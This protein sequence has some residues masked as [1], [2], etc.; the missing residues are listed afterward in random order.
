MLSE[1]EIRHLNASLAHEGNA[2]RTPL[3]PDFRVFARQ[4]A[5]EFI[6]FTEV[7]DFGGQQPRRVAV[8]ELYFGTPNMLDAGDAV[9]PDSVNHPT[10]VRPRKAPP[11]V[12]HQPP[13]EKYLTDLTYALRN[14]HMAAP[15]AANG[16]KPTANFAG[17]SLEP[18][19]NSLIKS[20]APSGTIKSPSST[21]AANC[22]PRVLTSKRFA[23]SAPGLIST[24]SSVG[25]VA[26]RETCPCTSA[27]VTYP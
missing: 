12:A 20:S 18:F 15:Y 14:S 21:T 22:R 13:S 6:D 2:V 25:L 8:L 11:V 5:D 24:S 26:P 4:A 9:E 17:E 7:T 3:S 23:L 16:A 10:Q 1:T 19:D 27:W